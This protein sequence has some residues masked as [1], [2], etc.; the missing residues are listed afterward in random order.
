MASGVKISEAC[1][2]ALEHADNADPFL[3]LALECP[4]VEKRNAVMRRAQYLLLSSVPIEDELGTSE[5]RSDRND[6]AACEQASEILHRL[7]IWT[8]CCSA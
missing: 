2:H 7:R 5:F 4:H 8:D 6:L 1:G 3:S